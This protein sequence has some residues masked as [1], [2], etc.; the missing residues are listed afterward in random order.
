MLL[1]KDMEPA[2]EH[3]VVYSDL[4]ILG[5]SNNPRY[6]VWAMDCLPEEERQVKDLYINFIKETHLG[7]TVQLYRQKAENSWWVEGRVDGK[8]CFSLKLEY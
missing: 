3:V 2:G 8:T 5:H 1:P 4:D 6:V 7:E